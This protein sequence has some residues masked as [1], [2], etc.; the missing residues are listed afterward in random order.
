MKTDIEHLISDAYKIK[1]NEHKFVLDQFATLS[2]EN[3]SVLNLIRWE[4]LQR[5]IVSFRDTSV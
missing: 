5:K 3:S 2:A 4:T 1:L